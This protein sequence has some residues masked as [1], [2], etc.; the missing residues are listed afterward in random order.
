MN[1][2]FNEKDLIYIVGEPD[3]ILP[4]GGGMM[5]AAW[6]CSMCLVLY[7]FNVPVRP[8]APCDCGSVFFEKRARLLQ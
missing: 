1:F 7:E 6:L 4:A 3:N 8:P 2:I 5:S